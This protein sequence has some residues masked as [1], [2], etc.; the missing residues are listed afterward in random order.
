MAATTTIT[1]LSLAPA[2]GG[3]S[4]FSALSAV[5]YAQKL[6]Q[7]H[8]DMLQEQLALDAPYDQM[9]LERLEQLEGWLVKQIEAASAFIIAEVDK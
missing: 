7:H 9:H 3:I 6:A 2:N 4:L 1:P 8:I 5:R